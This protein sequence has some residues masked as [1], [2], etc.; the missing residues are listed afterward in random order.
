[1]LEI[2]HRD[3]S[4]NATLTCRVAGALVALD[5]ANRP[6]IKPLLPGGGRDECQCQSWDAGR[7]RFQN[8]RSVSS[9]FGALLEAIFHMMTICKESM[10]NRWTQA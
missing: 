1:M 3:C 2:C 7:D 10:S 5:A 9:I 8:V 6:S 4:C